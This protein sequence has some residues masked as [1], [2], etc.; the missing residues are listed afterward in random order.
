LDMF[1]FVCRGHAGCRL[2]R[3]DV[4]AVISAQCLT[5]V[6]RFVL[7]LRVQHQDR[8]L[9]GLHSHHVR[10]DRLVHGGRLGEGRFRHAHL[11]QRV[12]KS[13]PW[14]SLRGLTAD[15]AISADRADS[16]NEAAEGSS[17]LCRVPDR[18]VQADLPL[19][20]QHQD[21]GLGWLLSH[22][23]R[24]DRLPQCCSFR[25]AHLGHRVGEDCRG[26]SM[27]VRLQS[28]QQRLPV[29]IEASHAKGEL[30]RYPRRERRS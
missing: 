29:S 13:L 22:H 14:H 15:C 30:L 18:G 21:R 19:R 6:S 16:G 10:A 3:V 9:G 11:G 27:R 7:P 17:H 25:R 2:E 8:G 26:N 1:P 5:V 23:V 20:V 24:A 4:E 28:R 12:G